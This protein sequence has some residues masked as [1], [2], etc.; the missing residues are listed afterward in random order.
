MQPSVSVSK[1]HKSPEMLRMGEK[2]SLYA[3]FGFESHQRG[4]D[5]PQGLEARV[6]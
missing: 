6:A 1:L 5:R 2:G 3:L 4:I